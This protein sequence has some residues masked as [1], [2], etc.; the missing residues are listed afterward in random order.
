MTPAETLAA[1]GDVLR[2]LAGLMQEGHAEVNRNVMVVHVDR[3]Q[4]DDLLAACE[5]STFYEDVHGHAN[6][7]AWLFGWGTLRIVVDRAVAPP[8]EVVAALD[9]PWPYPA[10]EDEAERILHHVGGR[11]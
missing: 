8:P 7:N 11:A 6:H 10:T 1:H 9:E 3:W 4:A 2:L 5:L